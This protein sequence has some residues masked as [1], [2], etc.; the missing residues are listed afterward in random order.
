MN[1]RDMLPEAYSFCF[2][3]KEEKKKETFNEE[4]MKCFSFFVVIFFFLSLF[5]KLTDRAN[6]LPFLINNRG[7]CWKGGKKPV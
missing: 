4:E 6:E 7:S 2:D 1:T 3:Y 5:L